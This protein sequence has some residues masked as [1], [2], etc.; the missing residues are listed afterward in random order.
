MSIE[1]IT[2]RIL[3]EA[4]AFAVEKKNEAEEV[5]AASVKEANDQIEGILAEAKAR[6]EKD[7][8]LLIA[9]RESV[10]DLEGRKMQLNAKQE[11]I[12]ESFGKALEKLQQLDIADYVKFIVSKLGDYRSEKGEILL[13]KADFQRIGKALIEELRGT[14]LTVSEEN[15]DISG[16]FILR[17]G[18]ISYNSSLEMLLEDAKEA[19]TSEIAKTLFGEK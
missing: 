7:S 19:M 12:E 8:K 4:E 17:Q 5:K 6:A 1:S 18:N 9:R 11:L 15:A 10:A 13:N 3:K 2:N 14:D 16:G